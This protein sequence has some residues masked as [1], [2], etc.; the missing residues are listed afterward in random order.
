MKTI[1]ALLMVG[2][3]AAAAC[4]GSNSK[5]SEDSTVLKVTE[6]PMEKIQT[7][8]GKEFEISVAEDSSN[9][10]EWKLGDFG[11]SHLQFVEKEKV[12]NGDDRNVVFKFKALKAG[13]SMV[14]LMLL[15][16][17]KPSILDSKIQNSIIRI[18]NDP[19]DRNSTNNNKKS[20]FFSI[21]KRGDHFEF[22][23]AQVSITAQERITDAYANN[24]VGA[25]TTNVYLWHNEE[26]LKSTWSKPYGLYFCESGFR[27]QEGGLGKGDTGN[28]L[29]L[30]DVLKCRQASE[31]EVKDYSSRFGKPRGS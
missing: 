23:L 12:R 18:M 29:F 22:P 19:S 15:N 3:L 10:K 6:S 31:K 27:L 11:D 17:R 5:T 24:L 4:K 13:T 1:H 16:S 28:H 9:G 21:S 7:I 26:A 8:V 20:A 14:Q 25:N 30:D 2:F